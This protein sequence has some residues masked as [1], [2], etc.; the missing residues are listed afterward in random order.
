MGSRRITRRRSWIPWQERVHECKP[1]DRGRW[2]VEGK[3]GGLLTLGGGDHLSTCGGGSK[4]DR[5]HHAMKGPALHRKGRRLGR[6][7]WAVPEKG[8]VCVFHVPRRK[9]PRIIANGKR[10]EG[11]PR[12]RRGVKEE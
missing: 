9:P 8:A 10:G 2:L 11:R 4:R 12:L 3:K 1:E 6:E 7:S 5:D